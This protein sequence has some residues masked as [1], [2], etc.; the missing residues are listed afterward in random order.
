MNIESL[1]SFVSDLHS[2]VQPYVSHNLQRGRD[3]AGRGQL[4]NFS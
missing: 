1:K 2:V 3:A 4:P